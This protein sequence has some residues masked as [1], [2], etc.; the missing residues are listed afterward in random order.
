M[1]DK[2]NSCPV[3]FSPIIKVVGSACNLRCKYC[4]YEGRHD[5]KLNVMSI[6]TAKTVI[7]KFADYTIKNGFKSLNII[8][9]GGEPLLAGHDFYNKI[10]NYQKTLH[11]IKIKN[12]IQTNGTL[13]N[14]KWIELFKR[15]EDIL[16]IGISL[17]G[18]KLLHDSQRL[19]KSKRGSFDDIINGVYLLKK[20]GVKFGCISVLTKNTLQ[21]PISDYLYFF[22]NL[23]ISELSIN[24]C[25]LSKKNNLYI[26]QKKYHDFLLKV[27]LEW[28]KIDDPHFKIRPV[29]IYVLA[30]KNK[31]QNICSYNGKCPNLITINYNGDVYHCSCEFSEKELPFGNLRTEEI[32]ELLITDGY[33][34]ML[35]DY[36]FYISK[37]KSCSWHKYCHGGCIQER[38]FTDIYAKGSAQCLGRTKLF[39]KIKNS[40]NNILIK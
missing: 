14:K 39:N 36:R 22:Y 31:T 24:Y 13:I 35:K 2:V 27:Y 20:N 25:I 40:V 5:E 17:D 28:L 11:R 15:Y 23:K 10:F 8:W 7:S 16:S 21:F 33:K 18:P 19:Y 32:D 38:Q 26:S 6:D 4:Y 30:S 3:N 1:A 12:S 9:H 34:N 37:C 29:Y